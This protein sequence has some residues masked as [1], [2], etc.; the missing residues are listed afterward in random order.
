M[1]NKHQNKVFNGVRF[2][3]FLLAFIGGVGATGFVSW[4]FGSTE[5]YVPFGFAASSRS[6]NSILGAVLTSIALVISLTSNLYTPRLV[7]LFLTHPVIIG[8][9]SLMVGAHMFMATAMFFP[10]DH[11]LYDPLLI[12]CITC[13]YSAYAGILPFLYMVSQFLRPSY[14]MPL[15]TEKAIKRVREMESAKRLED[16]N[17]QIY[18]HIN[19]ITNICFTGMRRGDRQLALLSLGCLHDILTEV[20]ELDKKKARRWREQEPFF[21]ASLAKEGREYL[22]KTEIWPEAYIL[23][24]IVQIMEQADARQNELISTTAERLVHTLKLSNKYHCEATVEMH[25]LVFNSMMRLALEDNDLRKFQNLSY[26]YRVMIEAMAE[27]QRWMNEIT[28]H[29]LHYGKMASKAKLPF[30][31]DTVLY[32]LGDI[33]LSLS[34]TD[35]YNALTFLHIWAGPAWMRAIN[36]DSYEANSAWRAMIRVFWEARAKEYVLLSET[37]RAEFL[38]ETQHRRLLKKIIEDNRPLHWEYN[39]RLLRFNYLTPEAEKQAASFS[40]EGF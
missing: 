18:S 29:L 36:E 7:Q 32:D 28:R 15:L 10:Q 27:N 5:F 40:N 25:I 2:Y 30:A 31:L 16:Y 9:L 3:F 24:Q 21:T 12:I 6:L 26:H 20:I 4:T 38:D 37:L 35:E 33:I 11:I 13:A 14:F 22:K 1:E 39:D 17:R 34:E 23:G 8:G 19:V